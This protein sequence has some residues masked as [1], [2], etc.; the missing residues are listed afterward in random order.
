MTTRSPHGAENRWT[1]ETAAA[2]LRDRI[3]AGEFHRPDGSQGQLPPAGTLGEHYQLSRN[4]MNSVIA[5]LRGEGLVETR[6]G[7]RGATV[8]DWK[9]LIFLPQQ[10]FE[11]DTGPDADLLTRLVEAA[12]RKGESR[13][14][15]VTAEPADERVRNRLGLRPGEH[16]A[17][18]RR[19]SVVD[20]L[21]ALTDDS[22]VPLRLVDGTDWMLP[23]NVERGTNKVLAE[24]G[25]E[26]VQAVDE[27]R[28][29]NTTEEENLRLGLGAG[30]SVHAIELISTGL[31]R[32]GMPV[33]VTVLTLP[34]P[35]NTVVYER[36]RPPA[37][38]TE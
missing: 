16:V 26:L 19:T 33:Q 4:A 10:E 17:V 21:P 23:V 6:P 15:S 2:D 8:R 22:Y 37:E 30:G 31:D 18:R 14:D 11:A 7:T 38:A 29:R 20:G 1:I 24:L 13:I 25:Y 36:R 35:R 28:P 27:L 9:Q 3:R 32:S 5:K 34:G 12:A